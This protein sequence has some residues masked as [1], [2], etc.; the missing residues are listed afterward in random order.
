MFLNYDENSGLTINTYRNNGYY[1]DIGDL[2]Q[3]V[4][5]NSGCVSC[6]LNQEATRLL[7][8]DEYWRGSSVS[9]E[10]LEEIYGLVWN[11]CP[12]MRHWFE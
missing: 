5:D 9:T 1:G 6:T 4:D 7:T 12:D 8:D 10:T 2:A 3:A 11:T